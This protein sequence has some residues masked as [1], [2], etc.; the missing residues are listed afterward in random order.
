MLLIFER[1]PLSLCVSFYCEY[2]KLKNLFCIEL[3]HMLYTDL[4]I[5]HAR[6][7]LLVT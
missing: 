5:L 3:M 7:L 4:E 6:S 1:S 2:E